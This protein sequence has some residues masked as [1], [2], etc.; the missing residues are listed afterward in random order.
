MRCTSTPAARTHPE[1]R[2][3]T[4]LRWREHHVY[5]GAAA[6]FYGFYRGAQAAFDFVGV[7]QR[8][9][10]RAARLAE[11]GVI[12]WRTDVRRHVVAGAHGGTIWIQAAQW[13][14]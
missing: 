4:L 1:R 5:Y 9:A 10:Q 12:G 3:A 2:R 13:D 8:D 7:A 14:A 6:G 11:F